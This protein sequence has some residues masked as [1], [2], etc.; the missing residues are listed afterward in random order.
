ML[1]A[2]LEIMVAPL[3]VTHY[4]VLQEFGCLCCEDRRVAAPR[5]L[6]TFD[7]FGCCLDSP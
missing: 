3:E 5:V 4:W 1:E 6:E 7:D 2:A